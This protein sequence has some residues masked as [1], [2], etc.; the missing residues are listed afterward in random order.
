MPKKNRAA[1]KADAG[2]CADTAL[3]ATR[4][5][6]VGLGEMGYP[7]A[8]RLRAARHPLIVFDA[9][10]AIRERAA[11]EGFKIGVDLHEIAC[12]SDV[13]I[14]MVP[15]RFVGDVVLGEVGLLA[16]ARPGLIIIDGGNSDPVKSV[17]YARECA[18]DGVTLLDIGFSGGPLGATAGTLA[19]MVGGEVSAYNLVA[20]IL[21]VV[22]HEIGYFGS[23]GNGHLA[24]AINH[25]VQGLTAQ[26]I[27]EA[28]AIA[29]A[30]GIDAADWVRV[31]AAGA[32]GSWLMNRAHDMLAGESPD[33]DQVIKWWR[34]LGGRNQLTYAL[35][36]A[37]ANSVAT[38]LAAMGQQIR[39]LSLAAGLSPAMRNYVHLTW[40]LAHTRN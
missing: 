22:G 14:V 3:V 6:M 17:G 9:L 30:A 19:V 13:V 38:P 21:K 28:L 12:C 23:S 27:G 8:G 15:S 29:Q 4:I 20:P 32:A 1:L 26:A 36:S 35:E 40:E 18:A 16:S 39:A 37:A 25:L 33:A 11:A 2:I 10:P 31:A 5:G 7:M 24:K 34:A